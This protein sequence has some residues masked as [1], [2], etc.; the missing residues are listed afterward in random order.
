MVDLIL[1]FDL[2][3]VTFA[4]SFRAFGSY[5]PLVLCLLLD[6]F[7]V[8]LLSGCFGRDIILHDLTARMFL[9]FHVRVIDRVMEDVRVDETVLALQVLAGQR[10][11]SI[12]DGLQ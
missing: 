2:H 11:S 6:D 8:L 3:L 1:H 9:A 5:L 7:S 10:V 12:I 4:H